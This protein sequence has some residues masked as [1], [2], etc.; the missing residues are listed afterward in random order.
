MN[1]FPRWKMVTI[2]FVTLVAML[3]AFPNLLSPETR[4]KLPSWLPSQGVNLGLD[5]RGGIHLVLQVQVEKALRRTVEGDTDEVRNAVR[6]EK[7]RYGGVDVVDDHTMAVLVGEGESERLQTAMA[8]ALPNYTI[9]P[10]EHAGKAALLLTLTPLS[11]EEIKKNAVDQAIE[12]IRNR[13]DQFGVSEPVIQREGQD[14]V[15]VQLP[16]VKD[17]RRAKALIGRTA[18]LEFKMVDEQGDLSA[19]LAGRVPPGDALQYSKPAAGQSATP[20]L[21]K[22]RV[23]LTGDLLTDAR[24]AIDPQDNQPLVH[25]TFNRKGGRKF[26]DLTAESVGKRM[27]I[28]LD[29]VVYSAPVIREKIEGGR[30]QISGSF[31]PEE[32]HDLA[33]VLRAGAL[34]APVVV[35]E[36]RTVGP[37]LGQDSIDAGMTSIIV[38]G[39]IVLIFMALYY[40]VFGVIADIALVFNIVILVAVLS[41][42]QATLTL[43]GMAGIVLTIGMAVDANV[44]I[45]ERIRE[46]LLLGRT[47]IA[48]IHSGYDKAFVTIMDSNITT[49][50]AALVLFGFGTGP[51]KGFAVT[52]SIGIL[53]SMFTAIL[54]TRWLVHLTYGR[55]RRVQS[56]AI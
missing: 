5:L 44:L 28:V 11:M 24:V 36:E 43:P 9:A 41:M 38:G 31:T 48:A 42:L 19:A 21:L 20:Y 34:P 49:L 56:L 13:I 40:R 32:A 51:V 37:S 27:A 54:V 10:G 35:A 52:L 47:P 6:E 1:E 53:A 12:T 15:L 30:A 4:D 39:V 8:K 7:L 50:I 16:G 55:R 25:I 23:A 14:R 26:A 45:F 18:L 3:F 33:I 2:V 46:E 22:K 29:G 17:T